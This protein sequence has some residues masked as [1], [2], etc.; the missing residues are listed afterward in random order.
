MCADW[1]VTGSLA[2][3]R[4]LHT[5]TLLLDGRVLVVGGYSSAG[6]HIASAEIYDPAIGTW[7]PAGTLAIPRG[8]HSAALLPDGRVL[9]AGGYYRPTPTTSSPTASAEI[10]DPNTGSWAMTGSMSTP[11]HWHTATA[12]PGG[13]VLVAGG[14]GERSVATTEELY[15][16]ATG[17]WQS[18]GALNVPRYGHTANLLLD[19]RVLVTGGSEDGEFWM[20]AATEIF[21]PATRSWSAAPE[22]PTGIL[23]ATTTTSA[24]HVVVTG[25]YSWSPTSFTRVDI[26]EPET[27]RW[28]RAPDLAQSRDGHTATLLSNGDILVAGGQTYL[29]RL[30]LAVE[31]GV[32]AELFS[33]ETATW[34]PGGHLN[35]D[36]S[37][38]HRHIVAGWPRAHRR[39]HDGQWRAERQLSPNRAE[40]RGA[41]RCRGR[42]RG[43]QESLHPDA[44]LPEP[45]GQAAAGSKGHSGLRP[46]IR[47]P[48]ETGRRASGRRKTDCPY[49]DLAGR[50]NIAMRCFRGPLD[51]V[52]S[53]LEAP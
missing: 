30:R 5:A 10:Y 1:H 3:A 29:S 18:A 38:A 26:F 49:S 41:L 23:N 12:L 15:D 2:E 6:A 36:R 14:W 32:E 39:W 40:Q 19:G 34:S 31:P 53:P 17:M 13:A 7:S 20:L 22:A 44:P 50:R 42:N 47:S 8:A 28:T 46:R 43:V 35:T 25:G 37:F 48:M 27:M 16:S 9:V 51:W 11:R 33:A 4:R 52:V 45:L 21:D 24:G